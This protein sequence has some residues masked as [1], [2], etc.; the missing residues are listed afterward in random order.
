MSRPLTTTRVKPAG[1]MTAV[2]RLR[3]EW[4]PGC[5]LTHIECYFSEEQSQNG[6]LATD[7]HEFPRGGRKTSPISVVIR[8][9]PWPKAFALRTYGLDALFEHVHRDVGFFL[10]DH[11]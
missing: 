6:K 3:K 4:I 7:E 10:R 9:N 1:S 5:D 2:F 8:V 11:Q